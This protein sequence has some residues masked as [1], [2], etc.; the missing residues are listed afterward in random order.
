MTDF[1]KI[2]FLN[3]AR[4]YRPE[5]IKLAQ[6]E[7]IDPSTLRM[8]KSKGLASIHR[9]GRDI[10]YVPSPLAARSLGLEEWV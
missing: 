8:L 7:T 3:M 6:G 5:L 2:S 1:D 4:Y 9:E 10:R